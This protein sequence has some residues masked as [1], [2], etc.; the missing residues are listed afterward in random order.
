MKNKVS[1]WEELVEK[2]KDGYI[3]KS[4]VKY[5]NNTNFKVQEMYFDKNAQKTWSKILIFLR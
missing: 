3:A 2:K 1:T 4:N 5:P